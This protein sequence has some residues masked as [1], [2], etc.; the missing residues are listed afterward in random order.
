[1]PTTG[2]SEQAVDQAAV[3]TGLVFLGLEGRSS[4]D[5]VESVP[6]GSTVRRRVIGSL[7]IPVSRLDAC[8]PGVECGGLSASADI[9][10]PDGAARVA[11][12]IVSC[13]TAP[14]CTWDNPSGRLRVTAI[15]PLTTR[16]VMTLA[17][18][19]VE[20]AAG[21]DQTVPVGREWAFVRAP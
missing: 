10:V 19:T 21:V 6:D 11:D 12:A 7:S 13:G 9:A 14:L 4:F 1:M 2:W 5:V 18:A 15:D 20:S 17:S 16:G 8:G 3:T